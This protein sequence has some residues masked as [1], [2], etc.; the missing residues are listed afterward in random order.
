MGGSR[1]S[2][3]DPATWGTFDA[4]LSV[5]TADATIAGIGLVLVK[6]DHITGVD[7]D[8]AVD[9]NGA[10]KQWAVPIIR[11]FATY[12]ELSPSG[13]GVHMFLAGYKSN[14]VGTKSKVDGLGPDG[15]G[16]IEVYDDKRYIAITGWPVKNFEDLSR[17]NPE[18]RQKLLDALCRNLWPNASGIAGSPEFME[19]DEDEAALAVKSL[20]DSV[21]KIEM[22]TRAMRCRAYIAKLPPAISGQGGHNATYRAACELFRFGLDS[23]TAWTVLQFFNDHQCHPAWSD[24]ELHHKL[25]Q[26]RRAVIQDRGFG[27]RVGGHREGR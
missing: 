25:R 8:R 15:T 14:Q 18:P 12:T 19:A 11:L 7:L 23:E 9:A 27:I 6:D 4:A 22:A 13:T 21:S 26:G 16:G 24:G 17:R 1:A 10:V 5:Y 20:T 2:V 3:T